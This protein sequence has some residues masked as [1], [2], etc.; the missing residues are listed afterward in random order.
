MI[1]F[2]WAVVSSTIF[3]FFAKELRIDT[4][5]LI[6]G[7]KR[8][9]YLLNA[10][11][12]HAVQRKVFKSPERLESARPALVL[13]HFQNDVGATGR[14][15]AGNTT[16]YFV[17]S[18][19]RR[20]P[21]L[22][23][24]SPEGV[25]SC[26]GAGRL[27]DFF[28]DGDFFPELS[29][30][31]FHDG[32]TRDCSVLPSEN[33]PSRV[34]GFHMT[35][36]VACPLG[37]PV[38]TDNAQVHLKRKGGD[39]A[40]DYGFLSVQRFD[41]LPTTK[42]G[43]CAVLNM[44][45]TEQHN[46]GKQLEDWIAWHRMVGVEAFIL[47]GVVPPRIAGH[48]HEPTFPE[49]S[50]QE[51]QNV[52]TVLQR[53]LLEGDVEYVELPAR[54][55]NSPSVA[56]H[57]MQV[58]EVND[59]IIRL[60][61]SATA[62][63]LGDLDEFLHPLSQDMDAGA[64]SDELLSSGLPFINALSLRW[65]RSAYE[66]PETIAPGSVFL[67]GDEAF[68][69]HAPSPGWAYVKSMVLPLAVSFGRIHADHDVFRESSSV[70]LTDYHRKGKPLEGSLAV[71]NHH[72]GGGGPDRATEVKDASLLPLFRRCVEL[73]RHKPFDSEQVKRC[74]VVAAAKFVARFGANL[75]SVRPAL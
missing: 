46:S 4:H 50:S 51:S 29:F 31:A 5:C 37:G 62:V 2:R 56:F 19:S 10:E 1:V 9:G 3:V 61:Q 66:L 25:P 70:K 72:F 41:P 12:M 30:E 69:V 7:R 33:S 45:T 32:R 49:S 64:L 15:V 16:A 20:D 63:K 22:L 53:L 27:D 47:Y 52:T 42:V 24:P 35:F 40:S 43:A 73:A 55:R 39:K 68:D 11:P 57:A 48:Q 26:S 34:C 65:R 8:N 13:A 74:R 44:D 59:C 6:Q 21:F 71:F 18:T 38:Q 17:V 67:E 28:G 23:G 36:T 58:A 75:T 60:R 54:P 14:G